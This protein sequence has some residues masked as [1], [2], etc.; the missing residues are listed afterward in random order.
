MFI[1]QAWDARILQLAGVV[2]EKKNKNSSYIELLTPRSVDYL[3]WPGHNLWEETLLL[4]LFSSITFDRRQTSPRSTSP[5][6]NSCYERLRGWI[7]RTTGVRDNAQLFWRAQCTQQTSP[8]LY[9]EHGVLISLRRG[10][11]EH[12]SGVFNTHWLLADV[13]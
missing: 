7:S 2:Q 6:L 9:F 10:R 8:D 11:E 5:N 12:V 1:P 4:E 13:W 3:E